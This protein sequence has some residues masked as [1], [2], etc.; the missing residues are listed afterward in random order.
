MAPSE[1]GNNFLLGISIIALV[2]MAMWFFGRPY[3]GGNQTTNPNENEADGSPRVES[4][5]PPSPEATNQPDNNTIIIP[6]EIEVN[7]NNN[8]DEQNSMAPS[9]QPSTSPTTN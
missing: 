1:T 7:V 6:D 3:F 4:M 9:A 2:I 8:E 5:T